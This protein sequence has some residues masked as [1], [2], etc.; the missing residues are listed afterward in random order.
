MVF[1]VNGGE[2]RKDS[3]SFPRPVISPFSLQ[4]EVDFGPRETKY[5]TELRPKE[6]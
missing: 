3:M 1:L 6:K 2:V 5:A 4:Y